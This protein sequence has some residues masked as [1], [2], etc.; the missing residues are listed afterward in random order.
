MPQNMVEPTILVVGD[1]R[2]SEWTSPARHADNWHVVKR[3]D[4]RLTLTRIGELVWEELDRDTAGSIQ[5]VLILGLLQELIYRTYHQHEAIYLRAHTNPDINDIYNVASSLDKAWRAHRQL[6]VVWALPAAPNF[7]KFNCMM[8]EMQGVSLSR[9]DRAEC[10][11][12]EATFE[13][14]WE[15]YDRSCPPRTCC[16]INCVKLL[17][18]TETTD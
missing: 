17:E 5:A 15:G 8:A 6:T 18:V 12:M 16:F 13:E 14:V 3:V 9:F 10:L 11:S 2:L 4:P 7:I 1:G